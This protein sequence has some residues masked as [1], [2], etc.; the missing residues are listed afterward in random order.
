M[1]TPNIQLIAD[2]Y[3]LQ[4]PIPHDGTAELYHALDRQLQRLVTVQVLSVEGAGD[5]EMVR[6]FRAH[7][8]AAGS[9][10]HPS[11]LEVYDAGEWQGRPYS[12]M[13]KD[14]ALPASSLYSEDGEPPNTAAVLRVTRQ[15]A[16]AL[17][18]CRDSGLADWAFSYRAV[19]LDNACNA[20]L[21][22]VEGLDQTHSD[23]A[24]Y[25]STRVEDDPRALS[26][27]VRVMM[28]GTPDPR[29]AGLVMLRLPQPIS[30]LLDRLY[31][32]VDDRITSAGEAA[33]AIASM[34]AAQSAPTEAYSPEMAGA[35]APGDAPTLNLAEQPTM[36]VVP[37][38]TAYVP[39]DE[40][41]SEPHA[42]VE[43]DDDDDKGRNRLPIILPLIGLLLLAGLV[44]AFWP[45]Q[46]VSGSSVEGAS[47]APAKDAAAPTLPPLLAP[48][49]RGKGLL[50]A[51]SATQ[52]AGL[53]LAQGDTMYAAAFPKDTIARQQPEAGAEVQPGTIITVSLSLGAEPPVAL[54]EYTPQPQADRQPPAKEPSEEKKSPPGKD[55]DDGDKNDKKEKDKDD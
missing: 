27:L 5:P 48:D 11:I 36:V 12:V 49:L 42:P 3:L 16:E 37:P 29:A 2:R 17:Q 38:P 9:L 15:A 7:Q 1:S 54:P 14:S 25:T 50:E 32:E 6:R 4:E 8:Q 26:G 28:V 40:V 44:A 21:L 13:E 20:R 45:R 52:A 33:Q 35:A 43:A 23:D 47:T 46:T 53:S 51:Q 18:H 39:G 30:G 10:H 31:L 24:Y 41:A 55:K 19:R 34:E 22:L